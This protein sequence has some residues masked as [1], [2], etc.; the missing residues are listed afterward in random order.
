MG[1]IARL[2]SAI[3][4][5]SGLAGCRSQ[6]SSAPVSNLPLPSPGQEGIY[7]LTADELFESY[8]Q[9]GKATD[10]L[11][12][13]KTVIVNGYI[14]REYTRI[15][16]DKVTKPDLPTNPNLYLHVNHTSNGFWLSSDGVVCNFPDSARVQLR[17]LL[18][19][20]GEREHLSVRGTVGGKLGSIFLNNC[21]LEKNEPKQKIK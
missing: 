15:E 10:Q 2:L 8:R 17:S 20:L 16:I 7:H 19:T 12:R 18:K 14:V 6:H 5:V 3:L 13:G 11:M 21:S 1:K 9:D 4:L